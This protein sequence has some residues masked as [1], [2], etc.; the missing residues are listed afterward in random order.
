M[1]ETIRKHFFEN[2]FEIT[3]NPFD[4]EI[5][6]IT[7]CCWLFGLSITLYSDRYNSVVVS[8]K[9]LNIGVKSSMSNL[10]P[11]Y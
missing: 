11:F 6:V 9:Y 7:Y 5:I 10:C 8:T 3:I 1:I 2:V 4:C